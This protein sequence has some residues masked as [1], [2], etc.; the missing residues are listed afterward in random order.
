MPT[1]MSPGQLRTQIVDYLQPAPYISQWYRDMPWFLDGKRLQYPSGQNFTSW[2]YTH[3]NI[4][5]ESRATLP[6]AIGQKRVDWQVG[7]IVCYQYRIP[8]TLD[9][10]QS[11]DAWVDGLDATLQGIVDLLRADPTLG[12]TTGDWAGLVWQAGQE[13]QDIR[14]Q[15]DLPRIDKVS[16]QGTVHAWNLIEFAL[17][18][19]IQA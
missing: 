13:N 3:L 1:D 2:A 15:R 16:G 17:T 9:T 5:H 6:V 14:I 4:Q 10:G 7:V 18:Q 19:I 12:T 8:S 11:E